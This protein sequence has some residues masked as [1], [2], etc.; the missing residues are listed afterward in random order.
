[1]KAVTSRQN[2]LRNGAI[3]ALPVL[4]GVLAINA[5]PFA[6]MPPLSTPTAVFE[7]V[8][9]ADVI[10]ATQPAVVQ[11]A[12]TKVGGQFAQRGR[13]DAQSGNRAYEEFMRRF[14]GRPFKGMP[15]SGRAEPVQGVGSG[16]L[17]DA[18]GYIVTN[19]HVIDGA[20]DITVTLQ[21]GRE[22]AA[23]Q[24]GIDA[25]T[26]LALLK[27]EG[28]NLPYVA[29]GDSDRTR[30][31]DWVV[32]IGS[33]FGFGG[34]VTAGI[35]SARGRDIRSG[36]YDD[37]LQ[38]DAPINSGNSG[39]PIIDANGQ[40]VGVNTAIYSPNG[41]NIGIG[42]AIPSAE[43]E[44]VVSQLKNNG[45]VTR[46]RLGVQ[47]QSITDD[48]AAAL[49]LPDSQGALVAEV[50]PEGA[51][52]RAGIRAGDVIRRYAGA[53]IEEPRDLSK[54]V[55][56]TEPGSRTALEVFRNSRTEQLVAT[57]DKHTEVAAFAPAKRSDK[58]TE[59]A[60]G[61]GLALG[62]LSQESRRKM[63]L[64]E[65]VEGALVLGIKAGGVAESGGIR[66]GD[67]IVQI[68]QVEIADAAAAEQALA[69]AK[70]EKRPSIVLIRR[71]DEQFFT[72][73]KVV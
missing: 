62:S 41:G 36:P 31:G 49:S 11:I 48:V 10:E 28:E 53:A 44:R 69:N 37:Y 6:A 68:D 71:G 72:T 3:V 38:I 58:A 45:A 47:I 34:S 59:D 54:A 64:D 60:L 56:R 67:V 46:G 14:G 17:I 39:G 30:V 66:P 15:R 8:Q 65:D 57:I 32:A 35:V 50:V 26:D 40:V 16:F 27:V 61:L 19:N 43:A 23:V 63:R 1:M 4:L 73:M 25:Q 20:T 24:V 9:F 22:M 42:F 29:F 51:A 33:P 55:A 21:D 5:R 7:R 13:P 70:Q 52:A 2:Y 12:V 18:D